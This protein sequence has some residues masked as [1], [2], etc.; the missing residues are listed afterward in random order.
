M[1][2][3]LAVLPLGFH[4]LFVRRGLSAKRYRA[5]TVI[6]GIPEAAEAAATS[7]AESGHH[8]AAST[9]VSDAVPIS[10]GDSASGAE[11]GTFTNEIK[12]LDLVADVQ[13]IYNSFYKNVAGENLK[14][15]EGTL[16]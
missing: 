9:P 2:L 6:E 14:A 8:D 10:D 4:V 15:R 5:V 1:L 11:C 13:D 12:L 7:S 3:E 16:N